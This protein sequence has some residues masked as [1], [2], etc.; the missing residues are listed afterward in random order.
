MKDLFANLDEIV[1]D[2]QEIVNLIEASVEQSKYDTTYMEDVILF[3]II[4]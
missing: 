4:V 3:C 1:T 2:E